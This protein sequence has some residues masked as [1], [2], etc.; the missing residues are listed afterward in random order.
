[1]TFSSAAAGVMIGAVFMAFATTQD[2]AEA[3]PIAPQGSLT[4]A[5]ENFSSGQ[6][7]FVYSSDGG[8]A[9]TYNSTTQTW[10][11]DGIAGQMTSTSHVTIQGQRYVY[12]VGKLNG[13]NN[14][15]F[16]V[17]DLQ[18]LISSGIYPDGTYSSAANL[19]VSIDG[20]IFEFNR[21]T[22][23][24][25]TDSNGGAN[26]NDTFLGVMDAGTNKAGTSFTSGVARLLLSLNQSDVD[27]A[28]SIGYT[29]TLNVRP[30]VPEPTALSL[31]GFGLVGVGALRRRA[32]G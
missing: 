10:N 26:Q 17:G 32:G 24:Y 29:V 16:S 28:A 12:T 18:T 2:R 11:D 7:Y 6:P 9:P 15:G 5:L 14:L 22:A 20:L 8:S 31:L 21:V 30:S 3:T 13:V 1:M 27:G 25:T 19:V 23:A 4:L